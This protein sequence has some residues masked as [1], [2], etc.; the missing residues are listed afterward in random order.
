[1]ERLRVRERSRRELSTLS[2]RGLDAADLFA[3]AA[4]SL[5][6]AVPFDGA[7]WLTLDPETGL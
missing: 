2:H 3:A 4:R 7:C 5:R 1:M 6:R